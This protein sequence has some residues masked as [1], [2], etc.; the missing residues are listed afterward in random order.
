[1]GVLPTVQFAFMGYPT[2][3]V[4]LIRP[5]GGRDSLRAASVGSAGILDRYVMNNDKVHVEAATALS[6]SPAASANDL[7][8]T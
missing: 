1:M 5:G 8:M 6:C 3:R 7:I 2:A 4:R